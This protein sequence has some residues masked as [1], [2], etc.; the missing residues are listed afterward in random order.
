[1]L[2]FSDNWKP[3]YYNSRDLCYLNTENLIAGCFF[4]SVSGSY[5]NQKDIILSGYAVYSKDTS[6]VLLMICF[7]MQDVDSDRNFVL[8][9]WKLR[10]LSLSLCALMN[11]YISLFK[12]FVFPQL[13]SFTKRDIRIV[14][15]DR[16][17]PF[18]NFESCAV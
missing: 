9:S 6:H 16:I 2:S 8:A 1:M 4:Q 5:Y 18:L 17:K 10:C 14:K 15:E 7:I 11:H 12:H 13:R 3:W